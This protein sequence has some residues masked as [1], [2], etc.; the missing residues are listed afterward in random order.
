MKIFNSEF[1]IGKDGVITPFIPRGNYPDAWAVRLQ[2]LHDPKS[3]QKY[4]TELTQK[5]ERWFAQHP[6]LDTLADELAGA[7]D[8]YDVEPLP[9]DDPLRD[10]ANV[11][12][13]PHI[14][15]RTRDANWRVADVIAD[16]FARILR[17]EAPL[18]AL[19]PEAMRVRTEAVRVP[20]A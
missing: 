19:T 5:V 20:G 8:V 1:I 6:D 17:G 7:F 13:T 4:R 12:H 3:G 16:D 18:A 9:P 2:D 15:G 11:V 14:A 10:R